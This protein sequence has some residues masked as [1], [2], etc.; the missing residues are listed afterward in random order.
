MKQYYIFTIHNMKQ[1]YIYT[2]YNMK[3]YY[4]YISYCSSRL[5]NLAAFGGPVFFTMEFGRESRNPQDPKGSSCLSATCFSRPRL[6][7]GIELEDMAVY[8]WIT[9]KN[10]GVPD[11]SFKD[12]HKCMVQNVRMYYYCKCKQLYLSDWATVYNLHPYMCP[13]RRWIDKTNL[14][15]SCFIGVVLC[16]ESM[17]P[18]TLNHAIFRFGRV[19]IL[20]MFTTF[21]YL[22]T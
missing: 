10:A 14:A 8:R 6:R 17:N 16:T 2:I 13:T 4:I 12:L 15:A 7:P 19:P 3:Q 18:H 1:Y 20:T 9:F 11:E 5:W 21:L 22:Q